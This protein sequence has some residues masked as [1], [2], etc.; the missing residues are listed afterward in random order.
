MY[1][2]LAVGAGLG[3]VLVVMLAPLLASHVYAA[4]EVK[5]TI[6]PGASNLADKAFSPNPVSASVGDNVTWTNGDT[7]AHTVTSGKSPTANGGNPDPNQGK[8]FDSSPGYK[9]LLAPGMSFSHVFTAAGTY[10]YFCQL[11]PTMVGTVNV[12]TSGQATTPEFPV[13]VVLAITAAVFGA[14]IFATRWN[15]LGIP[16]V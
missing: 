5:V 1:T 3:A 9:N 15:K 14:A 12:A 2:K 10:P 4:S 6:Q 7:Q 13:G 8:E 11:H 16:K